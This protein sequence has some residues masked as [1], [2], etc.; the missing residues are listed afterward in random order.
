MAAT[1]QNKE[2]CNTLLQYYFIVKTNFPLTVVT[3]ETNVTSETKNTNK[4]IIIH[5]LRYLE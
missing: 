1:H 3:S 4:M 2:I 5:M